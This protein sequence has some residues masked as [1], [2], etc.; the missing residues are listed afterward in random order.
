MDLTNYFCPGWPQTMVLPISTSQ[1]VRIIGLSHCTELR[2]MTL[3]SFQMRKP[4]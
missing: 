4:W 1:I 3:L 2:T